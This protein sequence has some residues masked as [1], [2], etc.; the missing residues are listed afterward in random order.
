ME[1]TQMET[2]QP[3]KAP[4]KRTTGIIALLLALVLAAA[5]ALVV[6]PSVKK[7]RPENRQPSNTGEDHQRQRSVHL[8]G[9]IQRSRQGSESRQPPE[10]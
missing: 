3:V 6:I 10:N 1:T 4:Q 8:P 2:T 9:N 5:L 7:I